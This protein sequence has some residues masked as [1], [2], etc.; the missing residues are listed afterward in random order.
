MRSRR[1]SNPPGRC[2]NKRRE[3]PCTSDTPAFCV[4]AGTLR[5]GKPSP[6]RGSILY[7]RKHG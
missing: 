3:C 4:C 1:R 2:E 7:R 6:F 5:A